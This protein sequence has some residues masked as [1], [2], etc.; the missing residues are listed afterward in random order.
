MGLLYYCWKKCKSIRL[1]SNKFEAISF[2]MIELT[3]SAFFLFSFIIWFEEEK[4]L[5][6]EESSSV[7]TLLSWLLILMAIGSILFD[8][9]KILGTLIY[10]CKQDK[11]KK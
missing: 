3:I 1:F 10:Q 11:V 9:F 4:Y 7:P 8:L 6:G 2:L 5:S